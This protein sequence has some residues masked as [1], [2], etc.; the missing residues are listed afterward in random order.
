MADRDR[1]TPAGLRHGSRARLRFAADDRLVGLVRGGDATAFEVLYDRHAR[2]LLSFCRYMLGSQADA[3]DAVQSTF[4]SA[5][6]ALLADERFVD[7]RPWLFT[8]ARNACL[9]TMRARRPLVQVS[10]G[11]ASND[12]PAAQAEQREEMHQV[13]STLLGLPESQRVA[14]LLSELHGFSHSDIGAL[15]GVRPEQVKS[16]VYQARSNLISDRDARTAD[17]HAIREELATARGAA[18][19]KSR[20]RRH[21]RTCAGCQQ[22]AAELSRQRHQ[23]G[24]LFPVLPALALKR[25]VLDAAL[26]TPPDGSTYAGGLAAGGSAAAAS[27]ELAGGGAKA[28]LAKLLTSVACLA[29]GTGATTAVL[30]SPPAPAQLTAATSSP[31]V[32]AASVA[33]SVPA[34]VRSAHASPSST[35]ADNHQSSISV[36]L[37][38]RPQQPQLP[39]ANSSS[40]AS[41]APGTSDLASSASNGS[42]GDSEPTPH[43]THEVEGPGK[44][45]EAHGHAEEP[46]GKSEEAHGKAEEAHGNAEEAHGKSEQAHGKA[47]EA[48]G[49]SE[50]AHG[51][52]EEAHGKSEEA[53][54]KAE[55]AHGKSEEAHGK[56]ASE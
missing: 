40:S 30:D 48:P 1:P 45:E 20:L 6:A 10:T 2:E 39:A 23:L 7:V 49:K 28:L 25:R 12:D 54:G 3:E 17:C 47:E 8:I 27:A 4:V 50:E 41:T 15:L 21:V 34:S 5:H 26:G 55:E 43:P 35:G 32:R 24:S 37:A 33:A 42:H 9:S 56:S 11:L 16:Y 19:L 52:S 44:S 46:H 29:G 13:L 14:L 36:T 53:P 38:Q 22:Y 31:H 18:L 51:K